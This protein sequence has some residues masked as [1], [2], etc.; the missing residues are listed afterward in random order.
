MTH[1]RHCAVCGRVYHTTRYKNRYCSR[2]CQIKAKN[3]RYHVPEELTENGQPYLATLIY[4]KVCPVCGRQ[5]TAKRSNQK[6]CSHQCSKLYR[7]HAS[8]GVNPILLQVN[9]CAPA[10]NKD[11]GKIFYK[12][13]C[14]NCGKEFRA[15]LITTKYCCRECARKHSLL[16]SRLE[17]KSLSDAL[18]VHSNAIKNINAYSRKEY[19]RISEASAF[20]GISEKSILWC[21]TLHTY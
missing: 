12:K 4:K 8:H 5:F 18:F 15:Q 6:Y 14:L 17:R 1:E 2:N 21:T 16:K 11:T 20:L 3:Y 7:K 13:Q 19:L 9:D 10:F